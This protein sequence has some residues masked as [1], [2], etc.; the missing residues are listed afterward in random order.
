MDADVMSTF[1]F[2]ERIQANLSMR[3]RVLKLTEAA[4]EANLLAA[5][6]TYAHASGL[7]PDW[8]TGAISRKARVLLP[9]EARVECCVAELELFELFREKLFPVE[10]D[11]MIHQA[12]KNVLSTTADDVLEVDLTFLALPQSVFSAAHLEQLLAVIRA[13]APLPPAATLSVLDGLVEELGFVN[14]QKYMQITAPHRVTRAIQQS[15]SERQRASH[16]D[17]REKRA[18]VLCSATLPSDCWRVYSMRISGR[19]TDQGWGNTNINKVEIRAVTA[20]AGLVYV[21][22]HSV[23]WKSDKSRTE[24]SFGGTQLGQGLDE[25][26]EQVRKNLDLEGAESLLEILTEGDLVQITMGCVGWSGHRAQAED[27]R[28]EIEYFPYAV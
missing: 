23:D 28:L 1:L 21:Q 9:G 7:A 26:D 5:A 15:Q 22:L 11:E 20:R 14:M 25:E 27:T 13:D 4:R 19:W 10:D 16:S 2:H 12:L 17:S 6:Q 8:G 18:L 3:K 24:V